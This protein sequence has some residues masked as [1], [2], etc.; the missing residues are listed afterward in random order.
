M[1]NTTPP[2]SQPD[3]SNRP[4]RLTAD[5]RWQI[6][7]TI[8][9]HGHVFDEGQF[10]RL[11]ELFTDDIVYDL[12]DYGQPSLVGISEIARAAQELGEG[13]PLAH[14]V[15]NIVITDVGENSVTTRC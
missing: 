7:E 11:H 5:E 13:N 15:T 4:R 1:S 3:R 12:S 6:A 8:A 10:D 14:H 2:H 9:L